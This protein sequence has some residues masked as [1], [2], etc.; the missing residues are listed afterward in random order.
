MAIYV[1]SFL[2]RAPPD[3]GYNLNQSDRGIIPYPRH[4]AARERDTRH[5][6]THEAAH[7]LGRSS[8]I[9]RQLALG[10]LR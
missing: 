8:V 5:Y 4:K 9:A 10:R 1:E 2:F 7:F 6:N 3:L